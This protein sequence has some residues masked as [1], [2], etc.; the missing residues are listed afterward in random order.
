VI[1]GRNRKTANHRRDFTKH[2]NDSV[3]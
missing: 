3:L 2:G 1:S